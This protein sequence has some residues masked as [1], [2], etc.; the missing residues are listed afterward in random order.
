MLLEKAMSFN[1]L[2]DFGKINTVLLNR[3]DVIEICWSL[4]K[5]SSARG[6]FIE[7]AQ[8]G[9]FYCRI[10]HTY[11]ESNARGMDTDPLMFNSKNKVR[12]RKWD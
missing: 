12:D 7:T 5:S 1:P 10:T 4:G 6:L 11:I 2:P 8:D 3:R 9:C